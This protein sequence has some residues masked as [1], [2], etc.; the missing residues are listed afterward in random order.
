MLD[1]CRT[2]V[3]KSRSLA[4]VTYNVESIQTHTQRTHT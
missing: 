4:N 3:G 2:I 1:V